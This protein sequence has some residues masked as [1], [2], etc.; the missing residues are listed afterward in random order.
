MKLISFIP[1]NRFTNA[2][3]NPK[4]IQHRLITSL[5]GNS[6]AALKTD[7]PFHNLCRPLNE[8]TRIIQRVHQHVCGHA[9]YGD[10]KTLLQRNQMWNDDV[11][12]YLASVI[13]RCSSCIAA[14]S[15]PSIRKISIAGINREF[16]DVVFID[17]LWLDEICLL[18]VMDSYSRFS[19][20]QPVQSTALSQAVVAFENLWISHFWPPSS[21]QGD[22]AFR[23]PE[24]IDFLNQYNISFRPVP[25]KKA[26]QE[27]VGAKTWCHTS[28]IYKIASVIVYL[29]FSSSCCFRC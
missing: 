23:F 11:Q 6:I 26:S 22:L 12:R 16:N 20:A 17:H 15:P 27:F 24:F 1:L 2:R 3:P 18:H 29:K 10:M 14:A 4:T 9:S 7:G 8:I 19:I 13:E 25:P 5:V 21:V 28:N